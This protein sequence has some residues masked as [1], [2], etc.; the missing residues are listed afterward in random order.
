[1]FFWKLYGNGAPKF[2]SIDV[3]SINAVKTRSRRNRDTN[4]LSSPFEHD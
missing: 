1:M 2:V 3:R 4:I